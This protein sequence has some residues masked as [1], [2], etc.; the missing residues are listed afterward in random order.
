MWAFALNDGLFVHQHPLFSTD[1][2][3]LKLLIYYDDFNV[4]NP[5]TNKVHQL[6]LFYCQLINTKSVYRGKLNSI[7]LFAICEKRCTKEFGLNKIFK[8]LVNYLQ[9]LG[10]DRGYRFTIAGGI[11]YLRGAVLAVIADTPA[12][13]AVGSFKEGVGGAKRK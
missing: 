12:S 8:P 11:V 6:G 1:D 2:N 13:Q 9:K 7:H 3:A 10:M 5:M 4:A